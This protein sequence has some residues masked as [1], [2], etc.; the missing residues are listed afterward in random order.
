[1]SNLNGF[2]L[3]LNAF[4]CT[5][6]LPKRLAAISFAR[7]PCCVVVADTIGDVYRLPVEGDCDLKA[8]QVQGKHLLLGH[9]SLLT[10]LC[11]GHGY[12]ATSDRDNRIRISRFPGAFV[13]ENFLLGHSALVTCVSWVS[14][15][16]ILSGGG[17]GTLRLWDVNSGK[18]TVFHF[19]GDDRQSDLIVTSVD[20]CPSENNL[21]AVLLHEKPQLYIMY[22]SASDDVLSVACEFRGEDHNAVI[23]GACFDSSGVLWVSKSDAGAIEGYK[24]RRGAGGS[25]ELQRHSASFVR[26]NTVGETKQMYRSNRA[27]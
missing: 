15:Y 23:S 16:K 25:A 13:I 3:F 24:V 6:E 22:F 1:M 7:T 5:S 27:L 19:S 2:F 18:A 4:K 14:K 21:F 17:D 12:I 10:D 9:F 8:E 26:Q 20:V 11:I